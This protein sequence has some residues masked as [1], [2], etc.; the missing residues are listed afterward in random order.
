MNAPLSAEG[1]RAFRDRDAERAEARQ[2]ARE[3]DL[4]ERL[5][6]GVMGLSARDLERLRRVAGRP[7]AGAPALEVRTGDATSAAD[8]LLIDRRDGAT[9]DWVSRQHAW[10][11]TRAVLWIGGP[12]LSTDQAVLSA[13]LDM[14]RLPRQL[15]DAYR[16]RPAPQRALVPRQLQPTAPAFLVLT[17]PDAPR[18]HWASWLE[19]S[20]RRATVASRAREGLAALHAAPYAGLILCGEVPD[21][22]A[23]ALARRVRSLEHRVGRLPLLWLSDGS[24]TWTRWRARLA[25]FD[26]VA[27]VPRSPEA[28][29]TLLDSLPAARAPSGDVQGAESQ[30]AD[31]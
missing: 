20:G 29:A 1:Q 25:G 17:G 2:Q 26:T 8:V 22:D 19:A 5:T 24:D 6:V 30:P 28:L 9:D 13:P 11:A 12:A 4:P 7:T 16:A 27:A 21:L 18:W 31:D 10:L 14:R 3:A 23:A 15:W